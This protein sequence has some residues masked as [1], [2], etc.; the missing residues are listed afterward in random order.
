M[1]LFHCSMC[2]I[3]LHYIIRY[4]NLLNSLLKLFFLTI[5]D[6]HFKLNHL[7][8]SVSHLN[9]ILIET[10]KKP[11]TLIRPQVSDVNT[12]LVQQL[13][14]DLLLHCLD[15][16]TCFSD[17][18]TFESVCEFFH[19]QSSEIWFKSTDNF[20]SS[21]LWNSVTQLKQ[22]CSEWNNDLI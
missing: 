18:C 20:L 15:L 19:V 16:W 8:Q 2:S 21:L 17:Y 7:V 1:L 6:L 4:H 5:H 22:H 3:Y 10:D 13:D 14:S 9:I 11:Q 12:V